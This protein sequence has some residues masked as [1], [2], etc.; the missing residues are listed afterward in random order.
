MKKLKF[1]T[2]CVRSKINR[3]ESKIH[4]Y[5]SIYGCEGPRKEIIKTVQVSENEKLIVLGDFNGHLGSI[6]NQKMNQNCKF[7]VKL[8]AEENMI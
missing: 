4:T 7:V 6:G 5:I 2:R 8:M 3:L 1:I